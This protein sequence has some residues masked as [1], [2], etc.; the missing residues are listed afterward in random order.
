M[1]NQGDA[2]RARSATERP[3]GMASFYLNGAC[4]S[5]KHS[6][7]LFPCTKKSCP[8]L[9]A[10]I[11]GTEKREQTNNR[12]MGRIGA[13]AHCSI[14]QCSNALKTNGPE[15]AEAGTIDQWNSRPHWGTG[16]LFHCPMLQCSENKWP[17]IPGPFVFWWP[18]RDSNPRFRLERA[19]S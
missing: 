6:P 10:L 12:A 9:T 11:K 3:R 19:A 5:I 8:M 4:P 13:L 18:Q 16:P 17:G 14:V 1:A 15:Y 7:P 2:Y